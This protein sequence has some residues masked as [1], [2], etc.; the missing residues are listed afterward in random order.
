MFVMYDI[1]INKLSGN[2]NH[3]YFQTIVL[4]ISQILL[5][6]SMLNSFKAVTELYIYIYIYIC[7]RS[8]MKEYI[9]DKIIGEIIGIAAEKGIE[10]Y[11]QIKI[12]KIPIKQPS[13]HKMQKYVS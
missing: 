1:W 3:Y 7:I 4:N 8:A 11:G 6:L 5:F 10:G 12:R 9:K 2:A 13:P